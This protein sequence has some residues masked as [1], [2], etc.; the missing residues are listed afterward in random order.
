MKAWQRWE[1]GCVHHLIGA[2]AFAIVAAA[3]YF[4]LAVALWT[5][6]VPNSREPEP[7]PVLLG[8]AVPLAALAV[9]ALAIFPRV[10]FGG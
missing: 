6:P 2:F 7:V 9:V 1:K 8:W 4:K 3:G 5:D 10:L